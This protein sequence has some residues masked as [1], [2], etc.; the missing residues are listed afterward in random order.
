MSRGGLRH[1]YSTM[2]NADSQFGLYK[3]L[4][5]PI[6]CGIYYNNGGR[7][8]TLYCAMVWAMPGG[9]GA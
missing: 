1:L 5:L 9:L 4:L 8:K 3:I 7:G 6:L 2:H